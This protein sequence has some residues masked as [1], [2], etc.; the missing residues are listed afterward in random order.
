MGA[1]CAAHSCS[2]R[3]PR[4]HTH[5]A[6]CW[7][8]VRHRASTQLV[9][10]PRSPLEPESEKQCPTQVREA[11]AG[12]GSLAAPKHQPRQPTTSRV[13]HASGD[14]LRA[15]H[16]T[17]HTP[18]APSGPGRLARVLPISTLSP[19][20]RPSGH[21]ISGCSGEPETA[22][23]RRRGRCLAAQPRQPLSRLPENLRNLCL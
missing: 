16:S 21:F 12:E 11:P 4:Q 17:L 15:P 22:A 2:N 8:P 13:R 3:V 23:H 1:R 10:K 14:H 9:I 20:S 19:T 6:P 18:Q 5:A 7:S